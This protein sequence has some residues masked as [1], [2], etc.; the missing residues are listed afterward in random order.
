MIPS[1]FTSESTV[2]AI[3]LTFKNSDHSGISFPTLH[4]FIFLFSKVWR[5]KKQVEEVIALAN[6]TPFGYPLISMVEIMLAYGELP[7]RW[8]TEWSVSI[9]E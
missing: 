7:K 3:N 1:I 8:N 5:H 2:Y 4:I 9:Q 6:D